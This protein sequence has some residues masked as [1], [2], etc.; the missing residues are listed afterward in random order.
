M[1]C[2]NVS[3]SQV[4]RKCWHPVLI[5]ASSGLPYSNLFFFC[6]LFCKF[7]IISK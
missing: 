5:L 2:I 3:T 1:S 4:F 6:P 7:E